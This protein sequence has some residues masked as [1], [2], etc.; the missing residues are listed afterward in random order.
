VVDLALVRGH[1][2][3]LVEALPVAHL[4]RSAGGA[5]APTTASADTCGP[6]TL[7]FEAAADGGQAGWSGETKMQNGWPAGS[8]KT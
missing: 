2:T 4:D 1:V 5:S 3:E 8:A 6:K 7:T